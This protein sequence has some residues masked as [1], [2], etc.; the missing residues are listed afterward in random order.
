MP[1]NIPPLSPL[2]TTADV[3]SGKVDGRPLWTCLHV[4][5]IGTRWNGRSVPCDHRSPLG[6]PEQKNHVE[7]AHKRTLTKDELERRQSDATIQPSE[8]PCIHCDAPLSPSSGV[9]YC[10]GTPNPDRVL[11]HARSVNEWQKAGLKAAL[12][13]LAAEDE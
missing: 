3:I 4:D 10:P 12:K 13:E 9:H 8:W 7:T 5:I 6:S 11:P 1:N 2:P